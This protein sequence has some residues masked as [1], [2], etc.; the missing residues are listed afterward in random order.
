MTFKKAP[1]TVV[2]LGVRLNS[3]LQDKVLAEIVSR[4]ACGQKTFV[5]T[6]NSEFLVYAQKHAWFKKI[7]NQADMAVPDTIGLILAAWVLG[8]PLKTRVTGADLVAKLLVVAKENGWR[9]GVIGARSG[10]KDER[11]KLIKKLQQKYSGAKIVSL[12]ETPD[13]P[14]KGWQ[15]VF[16]CQG[17]G[18]QEKWIAQNL[19]RAQE[20]GFMGVGSSLDYLTGFA[21]RAPFWLRRLGLEWL[22]RFILRPRRHARR[23]WRACVVFPY[24]ILKE[25]FGLI[26]V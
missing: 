16:A 8:Q 23:V 2:I 25:K 10:D 6:P 26:K 5:V 17:M 12:E 11:Q 19:P 7:L 13:W 14:K 15:L 3:T 1:N 18:K 20:G 22:W 4:V 24:L 21:R 9:V